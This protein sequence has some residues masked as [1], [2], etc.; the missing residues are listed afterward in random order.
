MDFSS[1]EILLLAEW[2]KDPE[3]EQVFIGVPPKDMH[4]MTGVGIFNS[5]ADGVEFSYEE[6][7]A[8]IDDQSHASHKICKKYRALGKAIN[9]S[10]QYRASAMKM[11]T[12]LFV[13][14]EEAQAMID[15]KAAAFPVSEQRAVD[16][17]E[18]VKHTGQVRSM[19]GA[20][21]HLREALLSDDYGTAPKAER[22]TLSYRIQGSA[23]EMTKLAEGRM[24]SEGLEQKFD[25]QIIGPI[26]DEVVASCA[27]SDL[28]KFIPAMHACMVANYAG[29][30]LPIR[31]SISFGRSF[32][33]QIEIGDQPT[34]EAV[35][36]GL[37][38]LAK[39]KESE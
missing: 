4:S 21:R 7:K 37:A 17:M 30:K 3:L 33:E 8:A 9:F 36:F 2:S 15:A 10:G 24:W 34:T 16:E 32:G 14:E 1:Q 23:A 22:Q 18:A 27:V 25:C 13:T 19:L 29:M 38:E 26:H 6:F 35:E 20:V 28:V 39:M 11:A 12:M 5:K 31:S